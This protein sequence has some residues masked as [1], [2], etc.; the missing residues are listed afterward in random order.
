LQRR[1]PAGSLRDKSKVIGTC[2]SK[3]Q[4]DD[5]ER[6]AQLWAN[7]HRALQSRD[8][9]ESVHAE[10]EL[11]DFLSA[12]LARVEGKSYTQGVSLEAVMQIYKARTGYKEPGK[13]QKIER[14][15]EEWRPRSGAARP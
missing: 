2:H 15:S 5:L 13:A 7:V 1:E 8:H 14:I 9:A 10:Q 4:L 6:D 12:R 3:E 11:A